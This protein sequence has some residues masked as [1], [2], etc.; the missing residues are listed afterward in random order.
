MKQRIVIDGKA[1][2]IKIRD[3]DHL[4]A[5]IKYHATVTRNKKKYTRKEKHKK[6]LRLY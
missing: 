1:K 5:C 2:E 6:D 3:L 4:N